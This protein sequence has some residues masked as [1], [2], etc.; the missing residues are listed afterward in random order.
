MLGRCG[1]G[2]SPRRHIRA[3]RTAAEADAFLNGFLSQSKAITDAF[4]IV[5][6]NLENTWSSAGNTANT[7]QFTGYGFFVRK[8]VD[9]LKK[10]RYN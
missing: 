5:S 8:I 1:S 4:K 6:D 2:D 7:T 3:Y 10:P 9:T